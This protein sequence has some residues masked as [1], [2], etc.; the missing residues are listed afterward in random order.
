MWVGVTKGKVPPKLVLASLQPPACLHMTI[1]Y[2]QCSSIPEGE[3][4][5]NGNMK[6]HESRWCMKLAV[7]TGK[8]KSWLYLFWDRMKI[9][10]FIGVEDKTEGKNQKTNQKNHHHHPFR[11]W[12]CPPS[13]L[14]RLCG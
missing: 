12:L 7:N 3:A 13:S 9:N 2:S 10:H 1:C 5:F 8:H 11:W 14:L 6:G 4:R